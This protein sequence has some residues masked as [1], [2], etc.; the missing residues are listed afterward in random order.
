MKKRTLKRLAAA[1]LTGAMMVATL[2]MSVCAEEK[3]VTFEKK[4][5]MTAAE[6][7]TVPNVTFSYTI[8][9]G[10]AVAATASNPEILA[11]I[12]TPTIADVV[13]APKESGAYVTIPSDSIVTK[14]ATVDFSSVTFNKPGIYRYIIEE[15]DKS[16]AE[17]YEDITFDADAERYLDVYVEYASESTSE[18]VITAYNVYYAENALTNVSGSTL[19]DATKKGYTNSY[20][21]YDLTVAKTVTGNMGDKNFEFPFTINFTGGQANGKLTVGERE[22]VLDE[23]GAGTYSTTLKNGESV[24]ITGI[25]ST[26]SYTVE[27]TLAEAEGYTTTAKVTKDSTETNLTV[28]RSSDK[29]TTSS[30][31]MEKNDN[32]V[33][34][35]NHKEVTTPT[36]IITTF[37]PYVLMVAFAAV[38]A[39][40]FLRRRQRE[41]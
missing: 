15:T 19:T 32:S 10:S 1:F 30:V 11:G 39:F 41:I 7:A 37:A 13:Y 23:N 34:V 31:T 36:G 21:T 20:T 25:P 3:S 27:E 18:C 4:L 2:G 38:V 8:S 35:T 14:T 40:F 22:I 28:T 16:T 26:V 9:A 33:N 5:D 6:G 17:G 12:G 24:I 29:L